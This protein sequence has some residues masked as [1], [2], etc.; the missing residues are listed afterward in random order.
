MVI[1]VE[2]SPVGLTVSPPLSID[3]SPS[4]K[5]LSLSL[6]W[7][8]SGVGGPF[9]IPVINYV[10]IEVRYRDSNGIHLELPRSRKLQT[11]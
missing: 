5:L 2:P 9:V 8:G 11:V 4:S 3:F 6:S 10:K 1:P 7:S